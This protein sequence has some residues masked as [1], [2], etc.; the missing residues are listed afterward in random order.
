MIQQVSDFELELMK[1]IWGNGGT[2]L[3]AEIAEAL[4]KKGTPATKNTIISL[5]SRLIEKGFLKTNKIGRRNRYTALVSEADYRAAQTETFLDKIY[6]G[7]AKDLISTLIQK[8]MISPDDYENLKKHWEGSCL[9][10]D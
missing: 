1:T 9:K 2:A 10:D 3:Y 6:E 7:S 5:L 8:E 4:E